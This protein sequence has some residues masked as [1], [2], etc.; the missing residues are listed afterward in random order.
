M[1]G[2]ANLHEAEQVSSW[3]E[4]EVCGGCCQEGIERGRFWGVVGLH[5]VLLVVV[6]TGINT[7][8]NIYKTVNNNN[9]KPISIYVNFFN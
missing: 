7:F 3:K 9:K 6:V 2:K 4:R 5:C 8:L 1:F